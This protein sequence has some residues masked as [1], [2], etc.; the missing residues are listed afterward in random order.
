MR[1]SLATLVVLFAAA[2]PAAESPKLKLLFLGDAGPHQPAAR[3]RQ[4]QPVFAARN[5]ELTYTDRL[6][7]LNPDT[8]GKYDG[9]MVLA[10]HVRFTSP[11]Q[12]K[13]L[14]EYISSG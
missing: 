6:A 4:L 14:L 5:V 11:V 13:E 8:L 12:Y 3:Y 7:D 1:T 9:M 2:A 10:N